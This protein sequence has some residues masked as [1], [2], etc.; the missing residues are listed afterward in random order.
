MDTIKKIAKALLWVIA[1][2][3]F[4]GLFGET[5]DVAMQPLYTWG[6]GGLLVL[7]AYGLKKLNAIR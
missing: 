4:I 3:S 5:T 2:I 7:S 6:M 1:T